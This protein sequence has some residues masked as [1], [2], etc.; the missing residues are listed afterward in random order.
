MIRVINKKTENDPSAFYCGRGS[1]F[2][3][4]YDFKGSK[5]PQVKYQVESRESAI[6]HYKIEAK[7]KLDS[8]HP[9]FCHSFNQLLIKKF[10]G[11][12]IILSC[13][14]KPAPCHA[15]IIKELLEEQKYCVNWF[16][17]MRKCKP[18]LYDG[19]E[20]S[21]VENFY[22]AMKFPKEDK[23]NR[24]RISLLS[25]YKAKSEGRKAPLSDW[26][27]EKRLAVMEYGLRKKWLGDPDWREKLKNF[28]HPI[29]ET[30]NWHDVF[31][32]VDIFTG[33]GQNHLGLLLEKIKKEI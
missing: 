25:P 20:F 5:H 8:G 11:E 1:V 28:N 29:V 13:F 9:E 15:D 2:G 3:N 27:D 17:N 18:F 30:N 22:Q 33:E 19:M 6:A 26:T 14:C 23:E 31:F 7:R 10:K 24:K 32:G 16:S 21:S 12:E 4:M